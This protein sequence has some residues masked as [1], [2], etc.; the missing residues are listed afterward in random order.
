MEPRNTNNITLNLFS[1]V[2]YKRIILFLCLF[3]SSLLITS[4]K[5]AITG[6]TELLKLIADGYE[7]NLEQ[8]R[9]WKGNASINSSKVFGE[10]SDE[11]RPSNY[12]QELKYESE[13]LIDRELDA[14]RWK[15]QTT[16][17]I[18][19]EKGEVTQKDPTYFNGITKGESDYRINFSEID[20]VEN[21]PRTLVI[22]KKE[23]MPQNF[24][25][26]TFNPIY[27]IEKEIG[28]S[29]KMANKLRFYAENANKTKTDGSVTRKGDIVTFETRYRGDEYDDYGEVVT[30]Y[31]FD[32]S[33][34]CNILEFSNISAINE[35]HW[36]LD[37]ENKSDVFVVKKIS[38]TYK[39]KRHGFDFTTTK[40]AVLAT[41]MVNE[42]IDS[43][44]FEYDK[45]GLRPGD[46][47]LDHIAG[48]IQ[49]Q[50]Q[51]YSIADEYFA[52]IDKIESTTKN[53]TPLEKAK[54]KEEN[55]N[56]PI[57]ISPEEEHP[58]STPPKD[59]KTTKVEPASISYMPII[60]VSTLSLLFL[61]VIALVYMNKKRNIVKSKNLS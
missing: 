18:I 25:S 15:C 13:F 2:H 37:Y 54:D 5:A 48:G 23:I 56:A 16:E 14:A 17:D 30:R 24:L 52:N 7:V 46:Y 58:H 6:D 61:G 35:R 32:L 43:T 8:L 1:K 59:Y 19:E 50:W 40:E 42:P 4:S 28:R 26:D 31:V 12:K 22:R 36:K 33:K 9:T 60:G 55:H 41:E 39:N 38:E 29:S 47:I 57:A 21:L 20:K 11:R 53:N 10:W 49:Y 45:I 3:L 27:A 34:G 44:E 51:T